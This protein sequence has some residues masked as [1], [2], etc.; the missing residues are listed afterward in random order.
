MNNIEV[1]LEQKQGYAHKPGKQI[2]IFPFVSNPGAERI[3]EDLVSFKG[4]VGEVFRSH[5]QKSLPKELET[6]DSFHQKLKQIILEK[7]TSKVE[8]DVPD[9][10]QRILSDLFFTNEGNLIKFNSETLSYLNFISSE[11]ALK[12]LGEFMYEAFF[13][14]VSLDSTFSKEGENLLNKLI[15]ESLPILSPS[16]KRLKEKSYITFLPQLISQFKNDFHL[17]N[18]NKELFLKHIEDLSK[19]YFFQYFA[20]LLVNFKTFGQ[21]E[22]TIYPISF[23]L[24]WEVLSRSRLNSHSISWKN[25]L[26]EYYQ[27]LFI[28]ANVLELLN[29]I[30]VNKEQVKDY[31]NMRNLYAGFDQENKTIFE[32]SI[33]QIISIYTNSIKNFNAGSS[34]EECQEKFDLELELQN[35]ETQCDQLIYELYYKVRYQFDN[36]DRSAANLRYNSWFLKFCQHNYLKFRGP[37][38]HALTINQEFLL[39]LTRL[40]VGNNDKIRL[41]ALWQEFEKRGVH[42]DENS[43]SEIVKLYEK[44]NLIEKKSDSGD[45]QYVKSII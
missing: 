28:H 32:N 44:I 12:N 24:D 8:T 40:C 42:F 39:F 22:E 21:R 45:A 30:Y 10:L 1:I 18:N 16:T 15:L 2:K 13:Q 14:S 41:K 3:S 23:T 43:K 25:N 34:W 4:V 19:F 9:D 33:V 11:G 29:N 31:H 17:L 27:S 7:A 20:Q 5:Q 6:N 35:F 26:N 37:L 36:S 38:G